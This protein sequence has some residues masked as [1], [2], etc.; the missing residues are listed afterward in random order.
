MHLKVY[1]PNKKKEDFNTEVP[2]PNKE[3]P[4]NNYCIYPEDNLNPRYTFET[5]VVGP[6]NELAYAAAQAII[7]KPV[8][9]NPLFFYGNTGLGKTHL[10]QAVG[11]HFKYH[12]KEKRVH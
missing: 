5:F 1:E 10:M 7:K 3:L 6:F 11:N 9:Y 4:L 12:N 2:T 8:A